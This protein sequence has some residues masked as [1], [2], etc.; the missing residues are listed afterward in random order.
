V[1]GAN[2]PWLIESDEDSQPLSD[3]GAEAA[4]VGVRRLTTPMGPPAGLVGWMLMPIVS[5]S[6]TAVPHAGQNRAPSGIAA[7]QWA[8]VTTRFY[9]ESGIP[10]F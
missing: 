7:A 3:F 10:E 5:A 1:P 4:G 9:E 2:R 8:Q 6:S